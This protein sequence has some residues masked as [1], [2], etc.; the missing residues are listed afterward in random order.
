MTRK[1]A[2]LI[3]FEFLRALRA[4]AV[5]SVLRIERPEQAQPAHLQIR[6]RRID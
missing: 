4:F 1:N 5:K 6:R 3:G 2:F